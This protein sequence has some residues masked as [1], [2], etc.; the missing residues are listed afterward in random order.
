VN[1]LAQRLA[2]RIRR[3]GPISFHDF[4]EAA[5][6]DPD[7]GYYARR[8]RIGEGGDFVTSPEIS[9]LFA[10]SVARLFAAD[11]ALFPG[12]ITFLEAGAGAGRFLADFR[13]ALEEVSP[14]T[15]GRVRLAAIERTEAGRR[16]IA[17]AVPEASA[18]ADAADVGGPFSGW[19]FSNELYDALPVHRVQM[20]EGRLFELG[21]TLSANLEE[22]A[23]SGFVWTSWPAPPVLLEPLE[24]FGIALAHGQAAEVNLEAA[25]LHRRLCGLVALG[26]I[27]AF[28]YGHRASVLY[29]PHAR[30]SGTL[31]VHSR[32]RRGGDPLEDPGRVDLTAHV[33]WDDLVSVGEASG[34]STE[35]IVR[36]SRFLLEAG[37]FEDAGERKL[38]ALRLFDPEG[39][40][41]AVSVLIQSRGVPRLRFLSQLTRHG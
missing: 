23:A 39:L 19:I 7:E 30:P 34:F 10:R 5:L 17:G 35:G 36:Q 1:P 4:M 24:R 28:D 29:H 22:R 15:G 32:G 3:E 37:L 21:V 26:R 13:S 38:E 18:F 33:N 20:R 11:A 31:A 27:V 14:E 16:A 9:S 2:D 8:A 40:G 25:S 41:E 12:P 6:Y